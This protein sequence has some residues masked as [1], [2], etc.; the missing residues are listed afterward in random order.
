VLTDKLILFISRLA[1]FELAN[2]C[3]ALLR[4]AA[5]DKGDTVRQLSKSK[6]EVAGGS[7]ETK[8]YK[9]SNHG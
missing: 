6:S 9:Q 4:F 3:D 5:A 7:D 2:L 8:V 1:G